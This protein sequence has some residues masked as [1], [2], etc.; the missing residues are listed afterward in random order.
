[1]FAENELLAVAV[2]SISKQSAKDIMNN[3]NANAPNFVVHVSAKRLI[4]LQL[5]GGVPWLW[6][7]LSRRLVLE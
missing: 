5:V 6:D 3:W 4:L 1:M 7:A 2:V